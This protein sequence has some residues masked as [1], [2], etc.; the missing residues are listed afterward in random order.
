MA[1][2]CVLTRGRTDAGY[3][4]TKTDAGTPILYCQTEPPDCSEEGGCA[5]GGDQKGAMGRGALPSMLVLG[6]IVF[7][8][9]DRRRRRRRE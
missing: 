9:I 8:T 3:L 5:V 4:P 1:S 2:Q 6:G 7:L